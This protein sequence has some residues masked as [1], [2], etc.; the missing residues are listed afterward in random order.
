MPLLSIV[1]LFS[2][3]TNYAGDNFHIIS[4]IVGVLG[5]LVSNIVNYFL[6]DSILQIHTLEEKERE[7]NRQL[8][9]QANKYQQIS[10]AYRNT[11]SLMHDT[12]K[13]F[14][15]IRE[16]LLNKNY[17]EITDYLSTAIERIENSYNRI[18]TGNLVIDAFVSNHLSLAT[19]EN[20]EFRTKIQLQKEN[21]Y[22]DDY[23]LSVILGN[24]LDNSLNACRKITVPAKRQ[25][26]VELFTTNLEFVIHIS[27]TVAR[28]VI[29]N[30]SNDLLHGYGTTNVENITRQYKGT[31]TY[32][33][34]DGFYHAIVSIPIIKKY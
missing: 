8:D 11:R 1:I 23:D 34:E 20:I 16:S 25:I 6:L 29:K 31:Y 26:E 2:L 15:Y 33:I 4:C 24:L 13:H 32:Y 18:N 27:N 10:T 30:T 7:L 14:L 28:E 22:I 5:L 17:S 3:T 19:Q 12:K 21:I 9:F